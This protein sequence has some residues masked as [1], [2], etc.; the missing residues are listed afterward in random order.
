M[1]YKEKS[2][3]N[4]TTQKKSFRCPWKRDDESGKT[5]ERS[6]EWARIRMEKK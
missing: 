6:R 1:R 2:T 5:K 4:K 3:E